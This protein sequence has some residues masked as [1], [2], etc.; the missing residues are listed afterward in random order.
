M[1]FF[2]LLIIFAVVWFGWL[3]ITRRANAE[4]AL[5]LERV[6]KQEETRQAVREKAWEII[7]SHAATLYR[8]KLQKTKHDD[9]GNTFDTDWV[10]EKNYFYNAVTVPK[11]LEHF[12]K[13]EIGSHVASQDDV[14]I[15]E[16]VKRYAESASIEEVN[17]DR[18]T[19]VEFEA[20]CASL[21]SKGG[22]SARVTQASGDQGID[23]IAEKDG[24]KAVFQVKKSAS[25]IG[26]KAVQE[27]IAGKSFASADKAFVVS[28]ASFTNSAK[29]LANI[30]GV[31][32]LHYTELRML[33]SQT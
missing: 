22:W 26:N 9:Y 5:E 1:E 28:N 13:E 2:I 31:G 11:L 15:E 6:Q 21:L 8:K 18:L 10:K 7:C 25:A 19:P 16:A 32:L 17:I 14:F 3:I 12:N 20:H 33:T 30:S 24:C 27:A 29:E 23:I 4:R